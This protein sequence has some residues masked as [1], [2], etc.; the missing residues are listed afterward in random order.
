MDEKHGIHRDDI[1]MKYFKEQEQ[2]KAYNKYDK[3]QKKE[4]KNSTTQMQQ[5]TYQINCRRLRH[6][7]KGDTQYCFYCISN[8][9][10]PANNPATDYF[11]PKIEGI[12][13]L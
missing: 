8:T 3:F 1:K 4:I 5:N 12:K 10:R 13:F 6:C 11:Q 2:K 7:R 9:T